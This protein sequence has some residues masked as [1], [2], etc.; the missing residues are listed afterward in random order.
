MVTACT[1]APVAG[2]TGCAGAEGSPDGEGLAALLRAEQLGRHA[3]CCQPLR[4][5]LGELERPNHG[6]RVLA[7]SPNALLEGTEDL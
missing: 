7:V 4:L 3:A 5:V 2:C 1:M 6:R